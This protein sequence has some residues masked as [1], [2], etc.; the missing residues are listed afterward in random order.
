M[1]RVG[2]PVSAGWS[3]RAAAAAAAAAEARAAAAPACCVRT[4]APPAAAAT[5]THTL[6][7]LPA[8][9]APR[10]ALTTVLI[11]VATFEASW[12]NILFYVASL[13]FKDKLFEERNADLMRMQ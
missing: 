9:A 11:L 2:V 7:H 12:R 5:Y 3:A 6:H 13:F 8:R 4:A 10:G 1:V